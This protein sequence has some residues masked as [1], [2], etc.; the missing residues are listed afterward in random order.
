MK[1]ILG[2]VLNMGLNPKCEMKEYFSKQLDKMPFFVETFSRFFSTLLD[3]AFTTVDRP[4][5]S[6]RQ[7][8]EFSGS[9][10]FQVP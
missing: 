7:S 1:A 2:V 10:K 4:R 8:K 9:H 6:W 5:V 3:V